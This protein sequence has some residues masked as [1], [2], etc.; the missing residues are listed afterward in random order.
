M[1]YLRGLKLLAIPTAL[2]FFSLPVHAAESGFGTNE[3]KVDVITRT[4]TIIQNIFSS[5]KLR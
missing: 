3:L 4:R 1:R 5:D 2:A